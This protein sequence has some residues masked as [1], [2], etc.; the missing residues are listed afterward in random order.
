[1]KNNIDKLFS[2]PKRL[3]RLYGV[4]K[5]Y[6]DL[7]STKKKSLAFMNIVQALKTNKKKSYK[8]SK[9]VRK[10]FFQTAEVYKIKPIY[11]KFFPNTSTAEAVQEEEEEQV[12]RIQE[13][14]EQVQHVQEEEE[15]VQHVQEE[16]K[17][18]AEFEVEDDEAVPTYLH[19]S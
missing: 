4:R 2:S 14:G 3:D 15:Q 10:F 13:E 7:G 12:Q 1:M 19:V 9:E 11:T 16:D 6:E 17:Q 5:L 18:V 8:P